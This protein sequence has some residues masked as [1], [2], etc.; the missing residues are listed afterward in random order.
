MRHPYPTQRFVNADYYNRYGRRFSIRPRTLPQFI[1]P[2]HSRYTEIIQE[3][4][5]SDL[6]NVRGSCNISMIGFFRQRFPVDTNARNYYN[7]ITTLSYTK[8]FSRPDSYSETSILQDSLQL[9]RKIIN[10]YILTIKQS[11]Q[12][13]PQWRL[14]PLDPQSDQTQLDG[15]FF[16]RLTLPAP[17]SD[18][19]FGEIFIRCLQTS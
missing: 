2:G 17:A 3:I 12:Q 16:L 5:Q 7:S 10:R 19:S 14:S 6:A 8:S 18:L 11:K 1:D 9:L 15:W 13:L 4:S